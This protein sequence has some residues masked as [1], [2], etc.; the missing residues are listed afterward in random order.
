MVTGFEHSLGI[1]VKGRVTGIAGTSGQIEFR[2]VLHLSCNTVF[3]FL[4]SCSG[5]RRL[6]RARSFAR[7]PSGSAARRSKLRCLTQPRHARVETI[8]SATW[9]RTQGFPVKYRSRPRSLASPRSIN[10]ISHPLNVA[11]VIAL[12]HFRFGFLV[13]RVV[14][15]V[16]SSN[17]TLDAPGIRDIPLVGAAEVASELICIELFTG[18][19]RCGA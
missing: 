2:H 17:R 1:V 12:L 18:L 6:H 9:P 14:S 10:C 19:P 15:R 16:P 13:E 4:R 8:R 11:V 5:S 7:S 3:R